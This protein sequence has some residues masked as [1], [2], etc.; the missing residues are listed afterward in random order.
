MH[1]KKLLQLWLFSLYLCPSL[2]CAVS[3][4]CCVFAV[5]QVQFFYI[6]FFLLKILSFVVIDSSSS[7]SLY[8]AQQ[9]KVKACGVSSGK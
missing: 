2:V 1:A 4:M 5:L 8:V 7:G 6:K 3:F 9:N